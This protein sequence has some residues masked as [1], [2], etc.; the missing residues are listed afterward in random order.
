MTAPRYVA[1]IGKGARCPA[2]VAARARHAGAALAKLHPAI[3]LICGGL[4]GVMDAGALGMTKAGGVCIG[5]VPGTAYRPSPHL[6]YALRLGLPP[7]FRNMIMSYAAELG[8]VLPGSHGT[9]T[10]G[11]AMADRGVPLIMCGS[12]AGYA[13]A[14]LPY[15]ASAEPDA[16]PVAVAALLDLPPLAGS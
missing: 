14:E 12:H 16:L 5:L 1:M 2:P 7:L 10:E 11:W 4:G 3:V 15:S 13:T 8:V 6:T 9:L